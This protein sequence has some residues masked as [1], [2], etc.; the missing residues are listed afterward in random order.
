[1]GGRDEGIEGAGRFVDTEGGRND[2]IVDRAAEAVRTDEESVA[3]AEPDQEEIGSTVRLAVE[4]AQEERAVRV[5]ERGLFVESPLVD[6]RLDP[7][8][9]VGEADQGVA[10]AEIGP[11][12]TQVD[13]AE[14]VTVEQAATHRRTHAV[15]IGVLG[16][17]VRQA[18]VGS[19]GGVVEDVEHRLALALAID[20]G[21]FVD[22]DPGGQVPGG[23]AAHTVGYEQHGRRGVPRIL[24][25]FPDQTGLGV[26]TDPQF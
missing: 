10:A 21:V 6:Q 1:V 19:A 25:V 15:E 2:G 24:I 14:V 20:L 5:G 18:P 3:A 4:D 17:Q 23:R 9:I 16:D 26:G 11:G 8:V 7:G 12:I 22:G 13:D